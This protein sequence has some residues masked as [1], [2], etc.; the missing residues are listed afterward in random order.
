MIEIDKIVEVPAGIEA[1]LHLAAKELDL[2]DIWLDDGTINLVV[3]ASGT[4][5]IVLN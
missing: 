3:Q 5:F 1:D 2:M 4:S